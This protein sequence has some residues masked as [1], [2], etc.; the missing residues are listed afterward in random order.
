MEKRDWIYQNKVID[1]K[2]KLIIFIRDRNNKY[3]NVLC[4]YNIDNNKQNL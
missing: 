4:Y 1:R 2:S 3:R